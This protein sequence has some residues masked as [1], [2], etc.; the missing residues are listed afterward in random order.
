MNR[1]G[2]FWQSSAG[3]KAVMAVTGLIWV[4]YLV[5]HMLG[6]L[7]VFQGPTKINGYSAMLHDASGLLWTARIVLIMA[8]VLHVVAAAQLTERKQMARPIGYAGG[9]APQVSTLAS[10]LIRWGGV[11]ILVFLV[12][13]ILHFTLGTVNPAFVELNPY[14]NVVTAFTNPIVVMVYLV[15]MVVVGLHLYHGLWSS[16]RTLGVSPPSPQ[17]LKRQI[18]LV[19]A[20]VLWLGFSVI[21][22]AVYFGLVR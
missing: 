15:A 18:A 13:H 14:H 9:R 8:F 17:P 22:I 7:L 5:T 12:Y 10:R 19:L 21:P 20:G 1:L 4:G 16:G 11:V 6:N 2:L 3:K